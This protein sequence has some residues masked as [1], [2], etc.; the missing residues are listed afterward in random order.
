MLEIREPDSKLTLDF[1]GTAIGIFCVCGPEAG[2]I[3]YSVD[4]APVKKLNTYTDWSD[5]LF[6]PWVYKL[7]SEL[8][9]GKHQLTM[10]MSKESD[11][12]SK[13]TALQ[14]RNFVVN[15]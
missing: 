12:R 1:E 14:I 9:P 10:Q 7:E 11:K 15:H 8:A 5:H 3:E 4:G 13:G 2:I 6:I